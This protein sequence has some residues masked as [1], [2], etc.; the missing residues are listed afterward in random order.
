MFSGT[1]RNRKDKPMCM[2]GK[3][4]INGQEGYS[5]DGKT[6][7]IRQPDPP[8]L[9]GDELLYDEPGRCVAGLDSHCHHLRLT[10]NGPCFYLLVRHGAGNERIRLHTPGSI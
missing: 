7:G 6:V 5:W 2:C 8:P 10:K 9:D 3:P 4:T 1:N